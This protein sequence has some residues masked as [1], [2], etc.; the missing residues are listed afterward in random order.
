MS[1]TARGPPAGGP[2]EAL[3]QVKEVEQNG[4]AGLARAKEAAEARLRQL[5]AEAETAV[6]AARKAGQALREAA[7]AD[8]RATAETEAARIL[9]E[10][11]KAAA[12]IEGGGARNVAPKRA[13][14]LTLVLGEFR[15]KGA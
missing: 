7:L 10:G 2:I 14:I 3:R 8:A 5:R 13:G 4:E 11:R 1:D 15:G 9:E 6:Q 12:A